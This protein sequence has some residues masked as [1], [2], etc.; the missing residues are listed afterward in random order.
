MICQLRYKSKAEA[1]VIEP[2][3]PKHSFYGVEDEQ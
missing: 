3:S 1:N 2:K